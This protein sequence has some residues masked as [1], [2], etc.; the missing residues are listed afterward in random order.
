MIVSQKRSYHN[1]WRSQIHNSKLITSRSPSAKRV[2][3]YDCLWQVMIGF[4]KF[5]V[6]GVWNDLS[7]AQVNYDRFAE[8]VI[9]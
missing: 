7:A 9:S 2:V 6:T 5:E 1:I 3:S 8:M 4:A